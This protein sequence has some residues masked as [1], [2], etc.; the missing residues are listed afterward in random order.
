M[1][2]SDN[3][4]QQARENIPE[5]PTPPVKDRMRV[6]GHC[7]GMDRQ[8]RMYLRNGLWFHSETCLR[9]S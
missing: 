7:A 8:D 1:S 2:K 5:P 3:L 4:F 9:V 6:C